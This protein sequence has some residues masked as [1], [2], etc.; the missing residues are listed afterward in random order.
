MGI[1]AAVTAQDQG[2]LEPGKSTSI[3]KRGIVPN[4]NSISSR[5]VKYGAGGKENHS[6]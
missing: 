6:G 2:S 1:S 4:E 3:P 5:T